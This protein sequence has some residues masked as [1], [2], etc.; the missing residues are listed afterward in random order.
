MI[1]VDSRLQFRWFSV[2]SEV[3]AGYAVLSHVWRRSEQ[4][5]EEAFGLAQDHV[6][7]DDDRVSAKVQGCHR[8]TEAYKLP[9]FW[10]DAPCIDSRN[11]AEVS[12]AI[13]CMYDW[14]ARA[15][16]CFAYLP[17]VPPNDTIR[18]PNSAFRRSIY[19]K[20]GWTL[21]ELIAPRRVV[22][23]AEDWTPIGEKHEFADVLEE[24]TGIDKGILTFD[25]TFEDVS[26]AR[27][28]SWASNRQTTRVEDKAYCLLGLFD[29][30]MPLIYGEGDNAFVRLQQT[31]LARIHDHSLLAWSNSSEDSSTGGDG[32][33]SL[34]TSLSTV[35]FPK[36][37]AAFASASRMIAVDMQSFLTAVM[38]LCVGSYED[39]QVSM[40]T[41]CS[42]LPC[43]L[44]HVT[45]ALATHRSGRFPRS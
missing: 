12:E 34:S 26:V 41:C 30:Q 44:A 18:A 10:V 19:F 6:A 37:P 16:I 21:Q 13:T 35:V 9:W 25:I 39:H 23:L 42:I 7:V 14:Y 24:I 20:R 5:F 43:A 28:L 33:D 8:L 1:P 31:I 40:L 38:P 45:P 17:D 3:D 2:P 29:I 22:F 15:S 32:Q 27:R 36:S 11:S 4:S